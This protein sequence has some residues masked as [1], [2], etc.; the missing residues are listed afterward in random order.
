M[1][2]DFRHP[3]VSETFGSDFRYSETLNIERPKSELPQNLNEIVIWISALKSCSATKR[4]LF[5]HCLCIDR[6]SD[7]QMT[8]WKSDDSLISEH[9]KSEIVVTRRI[10]HQFAIQ[11][12]TVLSEI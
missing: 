6:H 4:R 9:F 2:L 11:T 3:Y 5:E 8:V 12:F 7:R 10:P 1:N